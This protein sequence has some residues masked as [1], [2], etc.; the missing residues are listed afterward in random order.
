[1][2]RYEGQRPREGPP[3]RRAGLLICLAA[4]LSVTA[5]ATAA[6]PGA[7]TEAA[8]GVTATTATLNGSVVTNDP[9]PV[10]YHFEWGT[11]TAYGSR[12]AETTVTGGGPGGKSVSENIAGLQPSTMYH[13][14]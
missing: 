7:T 13:F 1:M 12:S 14:R 9:Q 11:T 2:L 10:T 6:P 5:V 3:L 8:T 4:A